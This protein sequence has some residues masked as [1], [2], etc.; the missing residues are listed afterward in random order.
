M[1]QTKIFDNLLCWGD[2]RAHALSGIVGG[3]Y[4]VTVLE[5]TIWRYLSNTN[6]RL[7]R[8]PSNPLLEINSADAH[9]HVRKDE[10]QG[11]QCS[12]ARRGNNGHPGEAG[13][14]NAQAWIQWDALELPEC[15]ESGEVDPHA[16]TLEPDVWVPLAGCVTW[17]PLPNLSSLSHSFLI[18]KMGWVAV[19]GMPPALKGCAEE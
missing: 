14:I 9:S 19:V 8:D 12:L 11:T 15:T 6:L 7:P 17:D 18:T 10:W 5:K 3:V 4:I 1:A 2:G 16:W 13:E